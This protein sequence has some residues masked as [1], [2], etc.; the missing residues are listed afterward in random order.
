VKVYGVQASGASAIHDSWHA[1]TILTK[2]DARTFADGLAT[3][4]VY[5]LTFP[6]LREGLA[7]FVAVSEEALA[8]ATVTLLRTTHNL[9]E[10]AA[11]AGLAGLL[12]LAESGR[13]DGRDVAIILSGSN[14]DVPTVKW[15][16]DGAV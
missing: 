11:A 16:L 14:I 7:D 12:A 15:V 8:Q 3:R 5:D 2:N 10:G 6:A 4:G 1:G 9:A 13:L